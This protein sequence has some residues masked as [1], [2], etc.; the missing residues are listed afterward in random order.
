MIRDGLVCI[1]HFL[2]CG[3]DIA[4]ETDM[5]EGWKSPTS[6]DPYEDSTPH[7]LFN[8][9]YLHEVYF[10]E[11]KDYNGRFTVPV[12]WDTKANQL[13]NNESLEILRNL[14][15]EF[16]SILPD[17]YAKVDMYPEHLRKEINEIGEWMQA[18][19]DSGVYKAGFAPDQATYD[20]NVIPVFKALNTLEELVAKMEDHMC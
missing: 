18:D 5:V 17:E 12:I 4:F 20:K 14:N 8:S 6:D 11:D 9:N 3:S 7:H 16:D 2:L 19:L 1:T 13:V 10:K 15:T